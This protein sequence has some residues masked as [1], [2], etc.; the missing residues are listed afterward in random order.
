M[1]DRAKALAAKVADLVD[2]R[3]LAVA[4]SCTAGGVAAAL[5]AGG[6]A[7]SWL[8]GSLVAYQDEVKRSLL[9]VEAE[10]TVTPEAAE[11][12]AEGV[13][14]LLGTDLAVATTG[15]LGHEPI[16]GVEP[17][18]VVIATLVGDDRRVVE[19]ELA[20]DPEAAA[21]QATDL[22]L[23]QLIGHLGSGRPSD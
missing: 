14:R 9:G 5:A 11:Q 17:S 6:G 19:H 16:D 8:T 23:Q 12:M 3:T 4:E 1:R 2:G 7:E 15:V 18:T 22:A 13:R 21:D 20:D 10:S